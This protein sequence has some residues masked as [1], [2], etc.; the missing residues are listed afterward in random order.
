MLSLQEFPAREL[1][2][3]EAAYADGRL[4]VTGRHAATGLHDPL[5]N[6][7]QIMHYIH[8]H[9]PPVLDTHIPVSI[10]CTTLPMSNQIAV[11][12]LIFHAR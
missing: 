7:M 11:L 12:T 3:Y 4:R 9:E 5:K 10:Q 8:R 2:Y 1:P 6:G